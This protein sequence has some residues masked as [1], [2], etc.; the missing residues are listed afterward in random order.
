MIEISFVIGVISYFLAAIAAFPF[1]GLATLVDNPIGSAAFYAFG[2]AAIPEEAVRLALLAMLWHR[3]IR[4]GD[5]R[6]GVVY[7]ATLALGYATAET[8][9]YAMAESNTGSGA[10]VAITRMT[11]ATAGHAFA[12]ASMGILVSLRWA[13]PQR[14][15]ALLLLAFAVPMLTHGLYDF[16]LALSEATAF[17]APVFDVGSRRSLTMMAYLVVALDL[18]IACRLYRFAARR[19]SA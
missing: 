3:S 7:G 11:T 2:E 9:D 4:S 13:I 19:R 10:Y 1:H 5:A 16:A 17:S 6:L 14:R 18:E 8:I 15:H 12:G